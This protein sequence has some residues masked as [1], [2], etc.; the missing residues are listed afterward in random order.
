MAPISCW[1]G[2]RE[3]RQLVELLDKNKILASTR[4]SEVKQHFNS[5]HAA[6]FGGVFETIVKSAENATYA[7]LGYAEIT[8]EDVLSAFTGTESLISDSEDTIRLTPNHL[9]TVKLEDNLHL[10]A[11]MKTDYS[12]RR[13]W[14]TRTGASILA[15]L[16][17]R[18]DSIA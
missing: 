15:P 17:S 16:S 11:R 1:R 9:Y 4:H 12:P 2:E 7:V 18:M 13:R 10:K 6:H 5:P 8:D 14:S 3:L